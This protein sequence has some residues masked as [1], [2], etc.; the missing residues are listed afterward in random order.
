MFDDCLIMAGGSGTRLWPASNSRLPKQFLPAS[1]KE[2]FFS[3]ALER[4]LAVI[5]KDGRVIIIAGK[6]HLPHVIANAAKLKAEDKKRLLVIGEPEAKNTA[7]AIAC[8]VVLSLLCGK[9]KTQ[10]QQRNMLVLTSDHIIKPLK[11]FKGDAILAL[12]AAKEGKLVVFGI[13]PARAETGYGYIETGKSAEN[14]GI[15]K[16]SAFHEK[17][18]L[19]TAVQYAASGNFFWNSGMFAFNTGFMAGEF[20][21]RAGDVFGP[22]E[23][24]KEA[25]RSDF[26]VSKGVKI[27]K[28]WKGLEKAYRKAKSISFDYA[29]AEKCTN[30]AMIRVSFDWIDIGNWEEYAKICEKNESLVFCTENNNCFVDSDIP[31]ALAGVED[32]IVVIRCGKNGKSTALI[33]KKGQTQKVKDVVEQ[34]RKRGKTGIL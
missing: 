11:I 10:S 17:P 31:V 25:K 34:I 33:T 3:M 23:K 4:A 32:L 24:L 18:D 28:T 19:E 26:S 13:P 1:E 12:S 8:A 5:K 15:Y 30:T 22:F 14:T 29:I 16:V 2:T 9:N 7:P 21:I 20:R 27:L 6:H